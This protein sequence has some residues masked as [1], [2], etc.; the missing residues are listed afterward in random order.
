MN[1]AVVVCALTW[2]SPRTAPACTGPAETPGIL[3]ELR[4]SQPLLAH[5][6]FHRASLER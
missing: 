1:L 2:P 6:T 4:F 3:M 5:G